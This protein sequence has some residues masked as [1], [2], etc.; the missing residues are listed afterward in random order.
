MI[1]NKTARGTWQRREREVADFHNPGFGKRN[2]LSGKLSGITGADAHSVP[3]LFIESRLRAKFATWTWYMDALHVSKNELLVPVL[4]LMVKNKKGF[5][6]VIHSSFVD[7]YIQIMTKHR[8][9]CVDP[10]DS[11]QFGN[12]Q[13]PLI[14]KGTQKQI[15]LLLI[16]LRGSSFNADGSLKDKWWK[17]NDK[18][19]DDNIDPW[20]VTPFG[21]DRAL[22]GHFSHRFKKGVKPIITE[23]NLIE[24]RK[25]IT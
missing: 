11:V 22:Y 20:I 7:R 19:K 12:L 25:A 14:Y 21:F 24:I 5:M 16:H 8:N 1:K 23:E 6:D 18:F 3:G 9:I 10:P 17:Y 2:P 4:S 15:D 13:L